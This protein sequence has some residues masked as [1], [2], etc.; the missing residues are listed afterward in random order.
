MG[1]MGGMPM[2]GMMGMGGMGGMAMGGGGTIGSGGSGG[3]TSACRTDTFIDLTTWLPD[4]NAAYT[5]PTLS[6]SC[7]GSTMTVTS[8]SVPQYKITWSDASRHS[9]ANTLVVS[10]STYQIP[11]T[12]VFNA[13]PKQATVV[14][15]VGVAVNGIQIS[16]PSASGGPLQ[17]ADPAGTEVDSDTCEGHPNPSGHYHY[18]AL[19][20]SC[21]FKDAEDG[22]LRG[23]A[24]TKASPIIGWIADGYPMYGPCECLDAAC[25]QVVEMRSS[26]KMQGGDN[27]PRACAYQD[28]Q[29]VGDATGEESD[30]DK[31]LDQCN[32]HYGPKGDYH[33]HM[34]NEYP[35]T[36]RC[37]RGSPMATMTMGHTYDASAG[38]NDCCFEKECKNGVFQSGVNCMMMS[39]VP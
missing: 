23:K 38:K 11:R 30:G 7:S 2:G 3:S 21:L 6:V 10:T 34:T 35:W 1:G 24:C 19:R 32:G 14:G 26:W 13:V 27:N 28:Y 17:Y 31:F 8:N 9:F 36:L 20:P 5:D 12:T 18:H 4:Q 25:T 16:S 22:D 39:C 37:Y 15:G 29:Y 33:Y